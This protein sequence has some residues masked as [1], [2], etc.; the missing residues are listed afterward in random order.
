[1]K[2][3]WLRITGAQH[4][5]AQFPVIVGQWAEEVFA[6]RGE[7]QHEQIASYSQFSMLLC[8]GS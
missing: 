7:E 3:P 6:R 2:R 5:C 1:M 8:S 4:G